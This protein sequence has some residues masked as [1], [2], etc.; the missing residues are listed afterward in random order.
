MTTPYPGQSQ[1][2]SQDQPGGAQ[3]RELTM[4]VAR[5][6]AQTL[7]QRVKTDPTFTASL[8]ASPRQ[9]LE[10]NGVPPEAV[11]EL[12]GPAGRLPVGRPDAEVPRCFISCV[13]SDCCL[14]I[15]VCCGTGSC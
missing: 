9:T 5:T 2:Q 10:A 3:S 8:V 7:A 12:I 4:N 13:T 11:N 1:T 6:I 15:S 14:T